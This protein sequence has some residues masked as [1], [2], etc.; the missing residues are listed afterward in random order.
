[1]KRLFLKQ[2]SFVLALVM[3]F[4]LAGVAEDV[5]G[6]EMDAISNEVYLDDAPLDLETEILQDDLSEEELT[7]DIVLEGET[8]TSVVETEDGSSSSESSD[9]PESKN[10]SI[11]NML[12]LGVKETYALKYDNATYKSSKSSV[13]AVNKQGV[14]TAK[15][16]GTAK[17]TVKSGGKT[18]ATCKV[19]VLAAPKKVTLDTKLTLPMGSTVTLKATLPKKTASNKLT[20]KSSNKKIV[21]VDANGVLTPVKAGKAKVTVTTFNK[22]KATCVV[23]VNNDPI[24]VKFAPKTISIGLGEA[25]TVKPVMNEGAK[26]TFTWSTKNKKIVTIDKNGKMTG[27]KV[28][29]TKITVKTK[30][31][32][33]ATLTV[34]VLKKPSKVTLSDTTV[35]KGGTVQLQAKLPNKTA[36]YTLKWTSSDKKIAKVDAQGVVTGIKPGTATITVTTFN[37]KKAT[38]TVTVTEPESTEAPS[39]GTAIDESTF[40]DAGLREL[41]AAMDTDG[42][43]VL[44]EEEAAGQKELN[45]TGKTVASLAGIEAFSGLTYLE[46]CGTGLM[47]ADLSKNDNLEE[48]NLSGNNLSKLDISQN[49]GLK[50]LDVRDNKLNEL[51]ISKNT[52]LEYLDISGNNLTKLDVSNNPALV[53]CVKNG[54]KSEVDGIV[55]YANGNVKIIV[56]GSVE[57]VTEAV[58]TVGTIA[59][60]TIKFGDVVA[61]QDTVVLY[62]AAVTASWIAEGDVA[63]YSYVIKNAGEETITSGSGTDVTSCTI[64]VDGVVFGVGEVYTLTVS[65]IPSNGTE[66]NAFVASA[67][68]MRRLIDKA[69][70]TPAEYFTYEPING[71]YARIT[72]YTGEDSVVVIPQ[73]I[74]DYTIQEIK[75]EAFLRNKTIEYVAIPDTVE[76]IGK[77]AFSRC[78]ALQEVDLGKGLVTLGNWVFYDDS[79]LKQINFPDSVTTMGKGVLQD[80]KN[81]EYVGYP[82]G[83]TTADK[84]GEVFAGCPKLTRIDI[85][86]GVKVIPNYAFANCSNLQVINL[87]EGLEEIYH[88]A[89]SNCTGLTKLIYPSTIK[90]VGGINGCIG[91]TEI[92]I[93]EGATTIGT[94]AFDSVPLT[95]IT[96]PGSVMEINN[97][98]FNNCT[99]LNSIVFSDGLEII[100][101]HAFEK[102]TS[103]TKLDLPDSV[104]TIGNYAFA[105][106]S[107]LTEFH[108]PRNWTT[109]TREGGFSFDEFGHNFDNDTKLN[110]VSIPEGVTKIPRG[111]FA[112]ASYIKNITVPNTIKTIGVEAFKG[113][114]AITNI[115]WKNGIESIGF[116]AFEGCTNLASLDLPDTVASIGCYAFAGCEKLQSFHYPS[117]WNSVTIADSPYD[118]KY[119]LDWGHNFDGCTKLNEINIAEGTTYIPPYAFLGAEYVKK[120][121]FPSTLTEIGFAAFNGCASITEAR[122]PD[123]VETIGC[124]AFANCTNLTTFHFPLKWKTLKKSGSPYHGTY[125]FDYGHIVENCEKL[126]NIEIPEGVE[127]IPKYAFYKATG[128]EE[129]SV[130][131]SLKEIGNN[132]FDGCE[133]F[134]KV[135]LGYNVKTINKEAFANCPALTIWTEYGATALQYAKDN[136][137]NYYYLSMNGA[138]YPTQKHYKGDEFDFYGYVRSNYGVSTL[139]ASIYS[140]AEQKNVL[141]VNLTPGLEEC[142]LFK[143][144]NSALNIGQLELGE[145]VF[146]IGASTSIDSETFAVSSFTVVPQPVRITDDGIIAPSGYL[147]LGESFMLSGSIESNYIISSAAVE[148][149]NSSNETISSFNTAPS[150]NVFNVSI[151]NGQL[152]FS[153]LAEGSYIFRISITADGLVYVAFESGFTVL[154]SSSQTS[155]ATDFDSVFSLTS[156]AEYGVLR[157]NSMM[158]SEAAYDEDAAKRCL[159][160][161]DFQ[162]ITTYRYESGAD[163]CGHVLGWKKIDDNGRTIKVFAVICRGTHSGVEWQSNF[164]VINSGSYHYGF[165]TAANDVSKNVEAYVNKHCG[166][167]TNISD[168]KVWVTG[169]SRGAAVAN[170]VA[171]LFMPQIGFQQNNIYGYTF[172]CPNVSIEKQPASKNIYNYNIGGDLVPRV[173]LSQWGYCRFG[174]DRIGHNGEYLEGISVIDEKTMNEFSATL[175]SVS[176]SEQIAFMQSVGESLADQGVT[177]GVTNGMFVAKALYNALFVQG[178]RFIHDPIR[179]SIGLGNIAEIVKDIYNTHNPHT[180]WWWIYSMD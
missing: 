155:L 138:T 10:A 100:G 61:S 93:P 46:C 120:V 110:T 112:Y 60:L 3:L 22:K 108:Y 33:S 41:V 133:N 169:H 97:Y 82:K 107:S 80:C 96:I 132:A 28:G 179:W 32:L 142:D 15:K 116:A 23:T 79:S 158:M 12:I 77:Q 27:K 141:S 144:I 125:Y 25:V 92:S 69:N 91:I 31:G 130:P 150:K 29:S 72:G 175:G 55:T 19:T 101:L 137:I 170:L 67:Q 154:S 88:H 161:L 111:A 117:S 4:S 119:Y 109:V 102:C 139:T 162:D 148:I 140:N 63:S 152:S 43:G 21:K 134:K 16:T 53:D 121:S 128:L 39:I 58:T 30:N 171:G 156:M 136:S 126:K 84:G 89:F 146:T 135:Y 2:I 14:I 104:S 36:S 90:T 103:L 56:N 51:D 62:D 44:S 68:F 115:D 11:P 17:I 94:N 143:L 131:S 168:C 124:Y 7:V 42:D 59:S 99:S 52:K 34:K 122:L 85:P 113:C 151:A 73:T 45:L 24:S 98:A 26:T 64:T 9:D 74:D 105:N 50:K 173:P 86:E 35:E 5:A 18:V 37:K 47:E 166:N 48:V 164:R 49:I 160:T 118:G 106:C 145:Y 163:T 78:S 157:K 83:W 76:T 147:S 66:N 174:I 6:V 95:T 13:A 114:T 177:G 54:T 70:P 1:M 180:Y 40:P 176:S 75:E 178:A 149:L 38:C 123:S 153:S 167:E 71:L 8:P 57:I 87:P 172:A 129:L 81:L 159:K 127:S 20:W 165:Y 65:A